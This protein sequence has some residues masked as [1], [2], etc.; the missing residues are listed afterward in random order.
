MYSLRS[1]TCNFEWRK[2]CYIHVSQYKLGFEMRL[3]FNRLIPKY[4]NW[5]WSIC[6]ANFTID[7][8]YST[9]STFLK[10]IN[11]KSLFTNEFPWSMVICELFNIQVHILIQIIF[12]Y[13]TICSSDKI[14]I[15]LHDSYGK[16]LYVYCIPIEFTF[17]S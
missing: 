9:D 3:Y 15:L 14:R 12:T 10:I 17:S 13:T 7:K 11:E 5:N 2:N 8:C 4:R 1:W 6:T 16:K